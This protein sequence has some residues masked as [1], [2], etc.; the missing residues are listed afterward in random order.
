MGVS[1][2][3]EIFCQAPF[4]HLILAKVTGTRVIIGGE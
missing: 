4:S 1:Q 3:G 2:T